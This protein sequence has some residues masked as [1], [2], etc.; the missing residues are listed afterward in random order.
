MAGPSAPPGLH[1]SKGQSRRVWRR[2]PRGAR[3]R[4][5]AGA[6]PLS[7]RLCQGQDAP[8]AR[9]LA[10][11]LWDQAKQQ[12]TERPGRGVRAL[13]LARD[14]AVQA[15][16]GATAFSAIDALAEKFEFDEVATKT[17]VLT[18]LVKKARTPLDHLS[19]AQE[20]ADLLDEAFGQGK[21]PQATQ[22]RQVG[23]RRGQKAHDRDIV[24]MARIAQ[25][26]PGRDQAGR[27]F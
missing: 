12:A 19:L 8:G 15:G 25:G 18:D 17:D 22:S 23:H 24:L 11:K 3:G 20:A 14:M 10:A 21:Y 5:E 7:R 4:D 27:G 2:L 26:G 16:D 1:P 6:G 13:R 9:A